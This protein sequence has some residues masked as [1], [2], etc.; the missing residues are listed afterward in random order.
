[1]R[2]ADLVLVD[3]Q[4]ACDDQDVP[5]NA[6]FALWICRAIDVAKTD[7][8]TGAE[9][10]VRI[11]G[12][13]EMRTLNRHYRSVDSPTNVLA[14]PAGKIQGLPSDGSANLG[15]LAICA[16]VV[17]SEAAEQGKIVADHWAHMLV[18][19]SLHLLGFDH[20]AATDAAEMEAMEV[21]ILSAHGVADPYIVQ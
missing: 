14:F 2:P 3:V 7:V 9:V 15:D 19:G 8:G 1:M 17:R 21:R 10:S 20:V 11:V 6:M 12:S 16:A 4:R 5:D 13:E 18:H